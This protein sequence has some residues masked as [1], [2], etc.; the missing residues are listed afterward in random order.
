M[1]KGTEVQEKMPEHLKVN[2]YL[3]KITL[4]KKLQLTF[5]REGCLLRQN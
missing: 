1:T 3:E 2:E 5:D 4:G